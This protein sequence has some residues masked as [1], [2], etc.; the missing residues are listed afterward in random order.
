[1][2]ERNTRISNLGQSRSRVETRIVTD[3]GWV[4]FELRGNGIFGSSGGAAGRLTF[5][6]LDYIGE[7]LACSLMKHDWSFVPPGGF[8][9]RMPGRGF[10]LDPG[11]PP[12]PD[13]WAY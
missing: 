1:M 7:P 3:R 6:C 11:S 12:E 5:D 9:D 8:V 13:S 4:Y 2:S 10:W